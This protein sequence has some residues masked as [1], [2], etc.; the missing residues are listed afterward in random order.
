M[1]Y[2][3]NAPKNF[4]QQEAAIKSV[5]FEIKS[6]IIWMR[7]NPAPAK[8][9]F[10]NV[11]SDIHYRVKPPCSKK[12]FDDSEKVWYELRRKDGLI[13]KDHRPYD[14][15]LDIPKLVPGFM[16]QPEVVLKSNGKKAMVLP[17]QLPEKLVWR[18]IQ[19]STQV[20]DL[21]IDPFLGIGTTM[22]VCTKNGRRFIGFEINKEY[23]KYLD[24]QK[25]RFSKS[26]EIIQSKLE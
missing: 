23:E 26:A 15:W 20:G 9:T 17:N 22:R 7:R 24:E 16:A 11:H 5:G 8:N 21:V 18:C 19:S 2:F 1:A 12:Y 6:Y 3:M 13:G 25:N 10:P 14:V 4:G